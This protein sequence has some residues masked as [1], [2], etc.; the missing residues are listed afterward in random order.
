MIEGFVLLLA[1]LLSGAWL[2]GAGTYVDGHIGWENLTHQHPTELAALMAGIFAPL[3]LLWLLVAYF[4]QAS[5]Q[6]QL[7]FALK[8]L[9]WQARKSAEQTE[10]VV[11]SLAETQEH[12]RH[13]AAL[14][15]TDRTLADLQSLAARLAV[16]F[17]RIEASHLPVF[18]RASRA[19]DRF[20]F[21]RTLLGSESA[22]DDTRADLI[23]RLG[24]APDLKPL[25]VDF[26]QMQDRLADFATKNAIHPMLRD[27]L[28]QGPPA[29]LS[30]L[31]LSV[32]R[33]EPP[34]PQV[35]P[36]PAQS[37]NP[38]AALM[39]H[40]VAKV[41]WPE[42]ALPAPSA[43]QPPPANHEAAASPAPPS[44]APEGEAK[45]ASGNVMPFS[46]L[47]PGF[48]RHPGS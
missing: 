2:L 34:T 21:F 36:A 30:S 35:Q 25:I 38:S 39:A 5:A 3:A 12:E 22:L 41:L 29:K 1:V 32:L 27:A 7:A 42:G 18:W 9:H 26:I 11:R 43:A 44:P 20:L 8:Q 33:A 13:A 4:R 6:R 40:Q 16:G 46:P 15:L 31:L 10:T 23:G 47:A 24:T 14:A 19:G 48:P 45:S 37:A 17:G 28:A